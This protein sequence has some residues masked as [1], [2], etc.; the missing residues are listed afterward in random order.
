MHYMNKDLQSTDPRAVS[1]GLDLFEH[2]K[3]QSTPV[4]LSDYL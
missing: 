3:K 2:Y 1:W 4:K